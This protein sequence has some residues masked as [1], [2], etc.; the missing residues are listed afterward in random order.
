MSEKITPKDLEDAED[1]DF[2]EEKEGWNT[3]KL[4]DGTILKIKLILRGV[5]RLK[6][7]GPDGTPIYLINAMNVVRCVHVDKK[8]C[9]KPKVNTFKPI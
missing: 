5:K 1:L 3:Y 7:W 2:S 8:L 9:S 6:K 4:S